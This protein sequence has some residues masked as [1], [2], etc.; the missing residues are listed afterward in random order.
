[1]CAPYCRMPGRSVANAAP[2]SSHEV[3]LAGRL[4][5]HV[6]MLSHIIGERN[7][8]SPEN[9][10]GAAKYIERQLR[11]SESGNVNLDRVRMSSPRGQF[12]VDNIILELPGNGPQSDQIFVIGA[13]YDTVFG[14][15]GANDNASGIA[16]LIEIAHILARA[17]RSITLRMVAFCNEEHVDMPPN[18][19]GS[20]IT[21]LPVKA[22]PKT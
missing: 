5:S 21:P 4:Q 22:A 11:A 2:L 7:E 18:T 17:P 1:M 8:S 9:L 19:M 6:A 16:S 20:F 15:A 3:L 14:S 13:H 12:E 10:T